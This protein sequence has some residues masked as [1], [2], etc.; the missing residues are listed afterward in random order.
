MQILAVEVEVKGQEEI[1]GKGR[2]LLFTRN[3][4]QHFTTWKL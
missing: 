2:H 1:H 3:L 4:I